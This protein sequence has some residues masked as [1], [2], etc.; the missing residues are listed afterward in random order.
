MT[1]SRSINVGIVGLGWPGERHAEALGA[2]ALGN[3]YAACDLDEERL[4]AF[5]KEF[6]PKRVFTRFDEMLLDPELDAVVIGL[7]NALHYPFSQRALQAGKHVLCE[8]PPTM[9]AGQMR[10]L[11]EEARN[12]GLVYYFGRQMRFSPAMQMAKRVIA[13]R[14]LGEIYFAETMWVRSRG[15]PAGVDGWFTDRSKAGGGAMIDLGVHAVDA[16]WYLMGTPQPR[17]VSAQTYQKFPQLVESKVFDVEDNAYGMIRFENSST[18][19]F[20][21]CWAANLTDDIPPDPKRGRSLLSTTVYG[22]KGSL[23]VIDVFN[24]HS[25]TCPLALFEDQQG[26]L[27]KS[28]LSVEDLRGPSLRAYEF[29][30]Q[31]KNF[32]RCVRGEESAVNSSSQA[33]QLMEMLDAIYRSSQQG[34]E[35]PVG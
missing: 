7:P 31:D 9:N 13:E 21:V 5:G 2:S 8:K 14:R 24:I 16:A 25:G 26:E 30:E 10:T 17:A 34:K 6:G 35:V 20:K 19:L 12:R 4:R 15:T 1:L 29:A 11:H 22:P 33:V 27:V 3:V 23:R 18:L 32:L 28:Q